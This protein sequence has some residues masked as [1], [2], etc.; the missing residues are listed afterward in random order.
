LKAVIRSISNNFTL[1]LQARLG[2]YPQMKRSKRLLL[3]RLQ[4]CCRY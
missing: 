3:G 1:Y 4:S 2:A